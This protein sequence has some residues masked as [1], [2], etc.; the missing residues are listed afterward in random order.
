MKKRGFRKRACDYVK[1]A[2]SRYVT[3]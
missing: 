1:T 3:K 2:H